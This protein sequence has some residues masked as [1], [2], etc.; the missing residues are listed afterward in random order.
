MLHWYNVFNYQYDRVYHD[1][2]YET[3]YGNLRAI[4]VEHWN[5]RTEWGIKGGFVSNW[6]SFEEENMQRN[7]Q[8]YQQGIRNKPGHQS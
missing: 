3:F 5:L 6:G 7:Q 2:G 1:R 4:N 8:Y